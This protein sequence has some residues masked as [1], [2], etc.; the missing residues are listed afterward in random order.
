MDFI[1]LPLPQQKPRWLMPLGF[2]LAVGANLY[3][4]KPN[5]FF[6]AECNLLRYKHSVVDESGSE[7]KK[8]S[9]KTP[10][11]VSRLISQDSF[12]CV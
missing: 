3:Q 6:A 9:V 4:S 5:S 8:L 10:S 1:H 2:Q 11:Y 12:N 7:G